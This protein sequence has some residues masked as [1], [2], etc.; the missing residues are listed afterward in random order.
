MQTRTSKKIILYLFVLLLLGTPINN[1]FFEK[2]LNK[3]NKFEISSLSEFN[4]REIIDDLSNY[5]YESLFLL[6]NEYRKT[7][8]KLELG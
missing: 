1:N 6:K 3:F 4:D 7:K 5:K 8:Q 2:S